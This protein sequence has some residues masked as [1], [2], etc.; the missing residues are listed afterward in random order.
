MVEEV[1]A[2]G[3][4]GGSGQAA[5]P[6]APAAGFLPAPAFMGAR[7]GCVFG[8]GSAGTGYYPDAKAGGKAGGKAAAGAAPTTTPTTLLSTGPALP[9]PRSSHI[10]ATP[11][12]DG[13]LG[14]R[15]VAELRRA[16]GVG[17]PR[18]GDSLYRPIER[19]PRKFNPLKVPRSL[20]AALPYGSKPVTMP[21]RTRKSLDQRRAVAVVADKG[22]KR[23]A[24]LVAQLNAIRN[25]KAGKRRAKE[26]SK[27]AAHGARLAKDEVWRAELRKEERKKRFAVAGAAEKRA[28][29]KGG[30][31]RGD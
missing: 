12:T 2:G 27:R 23:A 25:A 8:T 9:E 6:L 31:G 28:S 20:V 26:A 7:P 10:P 30:G 16:A 19:P 24:S 11:A 22:E 13:W 3:G 14:M 29:A 15:T 18:A 21:A 4:E 1:E 17:A 5:A